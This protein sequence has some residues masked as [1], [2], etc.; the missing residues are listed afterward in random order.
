MGN[1]D[2]IPFYERL[3]K[4]RERARQFLVSGFAKEKT[5]PKSQE[6]AWCPYQP[7]GGP[8]VEATS[9]ALVAVGHETDR[10]EIKL[11]N[12]A[13]GNFLVSRQNKDGG[14]STAPDAGK[15][16]WNTAP[17]LITLRALESRTKSQTLDESTRHAVKRSVQRGLDYLLDSRA[18]FWTPVARLLMLVSKGSQALDY[19][20]GWPWDPHCFHWVEPTSYSLI[21]LKLPNRPGAGVIRHVVS[22][23]DQFLLEHVCKG[24][25][26]NHGNDITLGAHLPPYRLTTAEALVALQ[27]VDRKHKAIESSLDYLASQE[28]Q[29]S[30][31]ISLAW[32]IIARHAYDQDPRKEIDFLLNRQNQDGSFGV[33]SN[34]H[35]SAIALIALNTMAKESYAALKLNNPNT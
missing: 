6:H 33:N 14:W 27:D 3:G 23:A 26:W 11:I 34:L 29:D 18:E 31:A 2:D 20:R 12:N 32:S 15:S 16:D 4:A 35:V 30:S 17:A 25:G 8:S 19:S 21:A 28:S 5:K 22:H 10:E 7:N 24:G 1:S 9:W 13:V